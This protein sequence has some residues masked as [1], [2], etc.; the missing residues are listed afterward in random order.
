MNSL[1]GR[2]SISIASEGGRGERRKGSLDVFSGSL[3]DVVQRDGTDGRG[4]VRGCAGAV[5]QR[6]DGLGEGYTTEGT[7]DG[8][9]V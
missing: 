2:Q 4:E 9:C 5:F 1:M 6:L 3:V 7:G 8:H